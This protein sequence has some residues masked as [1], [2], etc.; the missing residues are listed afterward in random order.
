[1]N[2]RKTPVRG[3][4]RTMI[5]KRPEPKKKRP[6]KIRLNK[7]A[8]SAAAHDDFWQIDIT[9]SDSSGVELAAITLR[10]FPPP[11]PIDPSRLLG[12]IRASLGE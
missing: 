12:W 9:V 3:A 11:P 1:M 8:L 10:P 6:K 2:T 5:A 4:L 7:S